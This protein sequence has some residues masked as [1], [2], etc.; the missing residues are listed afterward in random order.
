MH[1][2]ADLESASSVVFFAR[3]LQAAISE[4]GGATQW[5]FTDF[6]EQWRCKKICGTS[7]KGQAE[8]GKSNQVAEIVSDLLEIGGAASGRVV[9]VLT[10][11]LDGNLPLTADG[12]YVCVAK[13][14]HCQVD[15][16]G[17]WRKEIM[18]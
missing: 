6:V 3:Y 13:K 7:I 11:R 15:L 16:V 10:G 5:L 8:S 4:S 9:A 14:I 1:W 2:R 17:A 12:F 18:F